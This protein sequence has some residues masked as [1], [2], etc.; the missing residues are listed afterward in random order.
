MILADSPPEASA[1]EAGNKKPPETAE[2][3]PGP[4]SGAY[5]QISKSQIRTTTQNF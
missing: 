3:K 1:A 4:L 5:T 2:P